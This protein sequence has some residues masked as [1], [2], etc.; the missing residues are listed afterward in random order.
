MFMLYSRFHSENSSVFGL[1]EHA[2]VWMFCVKVWY[3]NLD[4]VNESSNALFWGD[5]M[6]QCWNRTC[7]FVDI[8]YFFVSQASVELS[9][10]MRDYWFNFASNHDPNVGVSVDMEW[11]GVSERGNIL[12]FDEDIS[13]QS[14][15]RDRVEICAFFDSIGYVAPFSMPDTESAEED[16]SSAVKITTMLIGSLIGLAVMM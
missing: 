9:Q 1:S 10:S 5:A 4:V 13:T 2:F 3:Y 11:S 12:V 14:L 8:Y 15:Y 16:E 6:S 7:H